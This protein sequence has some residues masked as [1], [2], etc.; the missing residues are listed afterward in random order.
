LEEG[1]VL[2]FTSNPKI[3][4]SLPEIV[5]ALSITGLIFLRREHGKVI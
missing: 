5:P 3:C 2:V 4:Y 1:E